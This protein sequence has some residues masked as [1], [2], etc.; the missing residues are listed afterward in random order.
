MWSHQIAKLQLDIDI[1]IVTSDQW[2]KTDLLQKQLLFFNKIEQRVVKVC[3]CIF[4]V[5]PKNVQNRFDADN[6]IIWRTHKM[7]TFQGITADE[8]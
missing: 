4:G 8:T 5:C 1:K 3:S 7:E 2:R 6:G